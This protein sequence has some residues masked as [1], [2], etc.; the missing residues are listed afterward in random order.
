MQKAYDLHANR[1]IFRFVERDKSNPMQLLG[2]FFS[3][4]SDHQANDT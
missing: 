4:N 1:L 2:T 3:L